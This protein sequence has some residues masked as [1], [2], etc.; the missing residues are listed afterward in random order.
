MTLILISVGDDRILVV[1]LS[2]TTSEGID[3][4]TVALATL[5]LSPSHN[6]HKD[7][8]INRDG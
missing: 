2:Q 3:F 7:I 8:R 4:I 5:S 6:I 1:T